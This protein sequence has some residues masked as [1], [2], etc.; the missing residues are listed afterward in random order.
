VVYR[1]YGD[2]EKY[3]TSAARRP[4]VGRGGGA[5]IPK[6][7]DGGASKLSAAAL[8]RDRRKALPTT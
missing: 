6:I 1:G 3:G 4:K 5:P 8:R 2:R 7:G